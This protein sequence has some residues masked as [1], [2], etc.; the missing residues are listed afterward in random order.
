[1]KT[2][3]SLSRQSL[4]LL[5][6]LSALSFT[7][8]TWS[9]SSKTPAL[10]KTTSNSVSIIEDD[11]K[12]RGSDKPEREANDTKSVKNKALKKAGTA[13]AAGVAGMKVKSII[14]D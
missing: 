2:Q 1:M 11:D 9:D 7:S 6:G 8:V 3:N 13:A 12:T 5:T 4:I 10:K 14:Q